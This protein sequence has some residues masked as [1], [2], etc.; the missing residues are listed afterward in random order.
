[1]SKNIFIGVC[2]AEGALD[3]YV[4]SDRFGWG[5][6]ANKAV[7]HNKSKARTYGELFREGDVITVHLNLETGTLSFDRNGRS[8]GVAVEGLRGGKFHC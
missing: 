5:Y 8:L 4:G 1:M 2:T 7:W 6:L 3:N